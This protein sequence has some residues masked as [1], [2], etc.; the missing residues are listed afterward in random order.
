MTVTQRAMNH[1]DI[2][3]TLRYLQVSDEAVADTLEGS[4]ERINRPHSCP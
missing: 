4:Q 2:R 1:A 3:S